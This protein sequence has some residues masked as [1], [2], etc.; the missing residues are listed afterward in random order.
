MLPQAD[1]MKWNGNNGFVMG[2]VVPRIPSIAQLMKDLDLQDRLEI[3]EEGESEDEDSGQDELIRATDVEITSEM[4]PQ[5][6]SHFTYFVSNRKVL[7]C[8]LQGVLDQSKTPP[9]FE[10]TDPV[11]HY[12]SSK[13]K[14]GKYGRTDHGKKGINQFF[15]THDCSALCR[16]LNL[17]PV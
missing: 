14:R 5:A 10:L 8:D 12:S 9:L 16:L 11:I 6:F 15:V 17:P 13:K 3:I 7:V 1:Y 4:V 2:Q